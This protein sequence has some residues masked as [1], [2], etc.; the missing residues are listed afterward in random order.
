MSESAHFDAAATEARLRAEAD[1]WDTSSPV[2]AEPGDIPVVDVGPWFRSGDRRDLDAAASALR[3][4]GERVGFHHLVGHDLGRERIA[5]ILDAARRFHG[6]RTETK[7]TILIDR[8][9]WPLQGVGYLPFG[10]RRLPRREKGNRNEAFLVKSDLG[11]GL[12]DNQWPP[13]DVLP[14]FRAVVEDYAAAVSAL[15]VRLLPLYAVA[16]DLE[17]D[18]F[19]P[20]FHHPFSRLRLTHYPT[21]PHRDDGAFGIAPHVDT[22]FFTLL[23]ADGP[24]LVIHSARRDA[25]V[26]VPVVDDAIVVNT[27]ELLRQWSNDRFLSTRHFA[28]NPVDGS[29]YSVPFF[30]NATADFPMVCLPSCHGPDN[31]PR[32]P[33]VSYRESQASV[34]GE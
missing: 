6:L 17:P 15:A 27:G 31:P 24:G 16:L 13:D 1:Q 32:Y 8:P 20:A 29:R 4:A 30:F 14:G 22:T 28:D 11:I 3:V 5:A 19:A 18:F 33:P 23:V 10:E 21:R 12:D 9:D 25:W 34:Q 2:A 26:T 7:R